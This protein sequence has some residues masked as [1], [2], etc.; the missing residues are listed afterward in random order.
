MNVGQHVYGPSNLNKLLC[1]AAESHA[2]RECCGL[3]L[4]RHSDGACE[5]NRWAE[6]ANLATD[7]DS[8]FMDPFQYRQIERQCGPQDVE[9]LGVFHSHP[10]GLGLPSLEDEKAVR[11][12]WGA[13]SDWIYLI[14]GLKEL[15]GPKVRGWGWRDNAFYELILHL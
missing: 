9:I 10:G 4:G 3:L 13:E 6:I 12:Q 1:D 14:C 2:P 15:P 5:I 8:F 7:P 11:Q